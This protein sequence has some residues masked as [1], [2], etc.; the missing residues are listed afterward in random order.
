M[1]RLKACLFAYAGKLLNVLHNCEK[2][3][4]IIPGY[5]QENSACKYVNYC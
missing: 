2:G 1:E 5:Y 4:V 3:N